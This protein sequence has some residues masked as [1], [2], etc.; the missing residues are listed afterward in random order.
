MYSCHS[1]SQ[2]TPERF[3]T[4]LW[5]FVIP[6][7]NPKLRQGGKTVPADQAK[8]AEVNER[9]HEEQ[10]EEDIGDGVGAV[11]RPAGALAVSEEEIEDELSMVEEIRRKNLDVIKEF[12]RIVFGSANKEAQN[13][14]SS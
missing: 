6:K 2:V 4:F 3:H 10:D 12:P 1:S 14:K 5:S 13:C 8:P 11:I 7:L 9:E